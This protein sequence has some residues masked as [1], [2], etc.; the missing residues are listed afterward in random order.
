MYTSMCVYICRDLNL[1]RTWWQLY[2]QALAK[3]PAPASREGAPKLTLP[4]APLSFA[5]ATLLG[6]PGGHRWKNGQVLSVSWPRLKHAETGASISLLNSCC[7][8]APIDLKACP[9]MAKYCPSKGFFKGSQQF[10]ATALLVQPGSPRSLCRGNAARQVHE[11]QRWAGGTNLQA[12]GVGGSLGCSNDL[13]SRPVLL[14]GGMY[15]YIN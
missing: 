5:L 13:P 6:G 3:C 11:P 7:K 1:F 14:L 8:A 9:C 2:L 10:P 15:I 12:R 4:K